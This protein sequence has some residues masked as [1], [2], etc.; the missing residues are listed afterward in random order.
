MIIMKIRVFIR[1][2]NNSIFLTRDS[3]F[4]PRNEV[5]GIY[6]NLLELTD[7]NKMPKIRWDARDFIKVPKVPKIPIGFLRFQR[8]WQDSN[9]MTRDSEPNSPLVFMW[10]VKHCLY[11]STLNHDSWFSNK[12]A[13]PLNKYPCNFIPFVWDLRID[14]SAITPSLRSWNRG[15][16]QHN[17]QSW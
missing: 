7:S 1:G 2:I 15:P 14:R 4:R 10:K 17:Q 3:I 9:K 5:S 8:F 13:F 16:S 11:L 12:H 6:W